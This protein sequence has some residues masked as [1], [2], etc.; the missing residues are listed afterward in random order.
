MQNRQNAKNLTQQLKSKLDVLQW[1]MVSFVF[2][3]S[4]RDLVDS[5][6]LRQ[7]SWLTISD[8]VSF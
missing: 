3:K 1:R 7:L 5:R 2:A 6:E 8:R 4:N